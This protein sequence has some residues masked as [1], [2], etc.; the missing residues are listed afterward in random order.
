[1]GYLFSTILPQGRQGGNQQALPLLGRVH[2]DQEGAQGRA[3]FYDVAPENHERPSCRAQ[4]DRP[5]R[6]EA[7]R[8][9]KECVR[10]CRSRCPPFPYYKHFLTFYFTHTYFTFSYYSLIFFFFSFF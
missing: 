6:S 5:T 2:P 7:R 8:V 4:P 1:M 9:W 3:G 10:T